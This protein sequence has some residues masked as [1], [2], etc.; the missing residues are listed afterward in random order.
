M[1][2]RRRRDRSI[3]IAN[4]HS[5]RGFPAPPGCVPPPWACRA[6]AGAL[7]PP[8]ACSGRAARYFEGEYD[9]RAHLRAAR[10]SL[11]R[12]LAFLTRDRDWRVMPKRAWH[13]GVMRADAHFGGHFWFYFRSR[14]AMAD[15]RSRYRCHH[16]ERRVDG[17]W[18][19]TR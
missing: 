3:A 18:K 12:W 13:M 2:H 1:A 6:E 8:A 11:K 17:A 5:G 9:R 19:R 7:T 14:E 15:F 10:S 16:P 4:R